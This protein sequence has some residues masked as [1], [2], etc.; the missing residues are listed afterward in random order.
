MP[1]LRE[2]LPDLG[3]RP[4]IMGIVNV[5][6]DSFS[7]DGVV[8]AAQAV[9]QA[10]QMVMDGA[11]ILDI[12]GESTRP[13]ATPVSADEELS[14]ILPVITA[15]RAQGIT[16]PISVDTFKASVADAA[17]QAGANIINDVSGGTHDLAMLPLVAARQCP[18]ILMHNRSAANMVNYDQTVGGEYTAADY[19]D[20]VQDVGRDLTQLATAA[21]AA[22][23]VPAN[24]IL[25]PGLGFG[26][27]VTQNLRLIA[28]V[29]ELKALGY[30]VLLGPSRKS[31]IGR[32]LDVPPD[33]RLEGTAACIAIAAWQGAD[34]LR[35]HDVK[36]MTR[37]TRMV[38]SIQANNG[39]P[40][41]GS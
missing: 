13:G 19:Q 40:N 23:V 25:D 31:F 6:P 32:V 26:K 22:G 27:S 35:V 39:L 38:T 11:D 7:G 16:T 20:I 14:R 12:G 36:A 1:E 34:I 41:F 15:L 24:I 28:A 9:T 4:L 10:R 29:R 30:P 8:D 3:Q 2:F 5:T 33:E 21:L 37:V 18:I 17:L